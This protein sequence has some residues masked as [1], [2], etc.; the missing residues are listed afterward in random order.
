MVES[1]GR[2]LRSSGE[3]RW[4]AWSGCAVDEDAATGRDGVEVW[5]GKGE[6]CKPP[7][8]VEAP[9]PTGRRLSS[10][11]GGGMRFSRGIAERHSAALHVGR[12]SKRRVPV[13]SGRAGLP[14]LGRAF[15]RRGAPFRSD[16][17]TTLTTVSYGLAELGREVHC[18]RSDG[19]R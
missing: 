12:A 9:N 7:D 16:E 4:L 19:E 17:E 18:S 11:A 13:G 3:R 2:P 5:K 10:P 1:D 14:G 6:P 8:D 15:R